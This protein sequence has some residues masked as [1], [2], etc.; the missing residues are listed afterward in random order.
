MRCQ[1][2]ELPPLPQLPPPR[3]PLL[4]RRRWRPGS[5]Q[6]RGGSTTCG[7]GRAAA[8]ASTG[9]RLPFQRRRWRRWSRRMTGTTAPPL[10]A[11]ARRA[12]TAS[13]ARRW[14]AAPCTQ[15]SLARRKWWM[16]A[17]TRWAATPC[18]L[19]GVALLVGSWGEAL[20]PQMAQPLQQLPP[21]KSVYLPPG[22]DAGQQRRRVLLSLP[23]AALRRAGGCGGPRVPAAALSS[24]TASSQELVTLQLVQRTPMNDGSVLLLWPLVA[25]LSARVCDLP[26]AGMCRRSPRYPT[27]FFDL[28]LSFLVGPLIAGAAI[29]SLLVLPGGSCCSRL[30]PPPPVLRRP[31]PRFLVPFLPAIALITSRRHCRY[32]TPSIISCLASL[33]PAHTALALKTCISALLPAGGHPAAIGTGTAWTCFRGLGR[34]CKAITLQSGGLSPAV[35]AAPC[36]CSRP[37][38]GR[39][40]AK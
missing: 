11:A 6:G 35:G 1:R 34:A 2:R 8:A 32:V 23:D 27:K 19:A 3:L 33:S 16:P 40:C 30:I 9:A 36:A 26:L 28:L 38:G 39:R 15:P 10:P 37:G 22:H 29:T 31:V 20:P 25:T 17:A 24:A 21:V 5:C 13:M 7:R 18:F 4:R 12:A 14:C